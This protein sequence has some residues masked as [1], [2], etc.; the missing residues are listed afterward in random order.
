MF[1]FIVF[2]QLIQGLDILN[3]SPLLFILN[4]IKLI[5][6]GF[7]LF[8]NFNTQSTSACMLSFSVNEA[9]LN[10]LY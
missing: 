5:E 2:I 4:T 10:K 1:F 3:V 8:F 6:T 9:E 7:N